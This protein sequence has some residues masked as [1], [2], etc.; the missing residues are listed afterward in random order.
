[1]ESH[2]QDETVAKHSGKRG[3]SGLKFDRAN[4]IGGKFAL[5]R[6]I[7]SAAFARK[8]FFGIAQKLFDPGKACSV[9]SDHAEF[10]KKSV[11]LQLPL[12]HDRVG[13]PADLL[14]NEIYAEHDIPP[15]A[16]VDGDKQR[17]FFICGQLGQVAK[18][19]NRVKV[20]AQCPIRI[21]HEQFLQH[22]RF[23]RSNHNEIIPEESTGEV[24]TWQKLSVWEKR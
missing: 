14:E 19:V 12:V 22:W 17:K 3:N 4:G 20:A 23:G 1:M 7:E 2:R 13:F 6:H 8:E 11:A 16:V 9:G 24:G 10:G 15:A 5:H 21:R 18:Q